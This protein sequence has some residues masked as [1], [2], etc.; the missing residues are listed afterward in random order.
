MEMKIALILPANK[1]FS[2]YLRIY[3]DLFERHNI[4]YDVLYW[5]RDKTEDD[6]LGFVSNCSLETFWGKI[7]SYIQYLL[8][9]N[10]EI[11]R[12]KYSKLIVFSSQL[13]ICLLPLLLKWFKSKYILD[14]RD[15][16]IEQKPLLNKLYKKLLKN[17]FCNIV[18]SPGFLQYLPNDVEYTLSHNFDIELVKKS[19]RDSIV[20]PFHETV[21]NVVTIG[22]IRDYESNIE[23]VKALSNKIDYKLEF[24]G[25]GVAANHIKDYVDKNQIKNVSFSGYYKKE[26]EPDL[27]QKATFLNI[28]Y[29]IKPSHNTALSNRFYNSLVFKR[30]MIV[31]KNTIQGDFVDKYNLGLALSDCNDLDIKLR[32]YL[33]NNDYES[34]CHRANLLLE[35]FVSDYN[36]FENKILSFLH[37]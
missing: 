15:L 25:K 2:P 19:L 36:K 27:I 22:G 26:D 4:Q 6:R 33:K 14:F 23:V 28:F 29:P 7:K 18:S 31:T 24:I 1:W 17:S 11:K 13:S 12:N 16:S 32:D 8:F 30:P 21:I 5:N 37:S 10:R 20:K 34:F 9:I 35:R 3:T